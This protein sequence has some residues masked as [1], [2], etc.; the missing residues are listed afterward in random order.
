MSKLTLS[1]PKAGDLLTL[2]EPGPHYLRFLQEYS[3]DI[4]IRADMTI[5]STSYQS[6]TK[7]DTE[8]AQQ[9]ATHN[10]GNEEDGIEDV[11]S[12]EARA[13]AERDFTFIVSTYCI[14]PFTSRLN[15]STSPAHVAAPT[16]KVTRQIFGELSASQQ[17]KSRSANV[18]DTRTAIMWYFGPA[19][20]EKCPGVHNKRLGLG[21]QHQ[22]S[23]WQIVR[24]LVKQRIE[25]LR[26]MKQEN[27]KS[28]FK[29]RIKG[30]KIHVLRI[31]ERLSHKL[32]AATKGG[33]LEE[34]F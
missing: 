21:I 15:T 18:E 24:C 30:V 5:R 26:S 22:L 19:G 8:D 20:V 23:V 34:V 29:R 14:R 3:K 17:E 25:R 9:R 1:L 12:D 28:S 33:C 4:L 16:R 10:P 31:G 7:V 2:S 6:I 32:L 13:Q 11:A 27:I